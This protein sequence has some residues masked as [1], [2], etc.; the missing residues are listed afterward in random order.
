MSKTN[1]PVQRISQ[2]W[3]VLYRFKAVKLLTWKQCMH[4]IDFFIYI[5]KKKMHKYENLWYLL[6]WNGFGQ[7]LTT[8]NQVEPLHEHNACSP[9][10][11]VAVGYTSELFDENEHE[12]RRDSE[13]FAPQHHHP[14]SRHRHHKVKHH[15]HHSAQ[16]SKVSKGSIKW[17]KP[18]VWEKYVWPQTYN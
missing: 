11:P 13:R 18:S 3:K 6:W 8:R 17:I 2:W 14:V 4:I 1:V 7:V 12:R 10:E 15:R 16:H 9:N 5:V